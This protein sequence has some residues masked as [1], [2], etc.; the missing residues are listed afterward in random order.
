M[1]RANLE[2][3]GLTDFEQH[4][5]YHLSGGMQQRVGLARALT[6]DPEI[7]LMDEPLGALDAFTRETMQELILEVW[8]RTHKVVFFITHSVEE[9]LFMATRLIVMSPRPG[10]ITHEYSLDFCKRF[11]EQG[12]ARKI[13]SDPDFIKMREEILSIIYG[14]E[15]EEVEA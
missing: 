3:V 12:E 4:P 13:K 15:L 2:L 1:A 5:I 6:S 8:D 14:E 9:A 7:L 11:I 10:R